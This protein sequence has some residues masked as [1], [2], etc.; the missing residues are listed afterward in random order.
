[1]IIRTTYEIFLDPTTESERVQEMQKMKGYVC[2]CE[3]SSLVVF[4]KID[5]VEVT[6]KD[7]KGEER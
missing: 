1:M 7:M 3:V 2:V 6:D 4:R 5:E